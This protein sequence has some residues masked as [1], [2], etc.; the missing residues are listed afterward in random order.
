MVAIEA[1]VPRRSR[2]ER[3]KKQ[4]GT[5]RERERN[6]Q[7]ADNQQ[8]TEPS[9]AQGRAP[10]LAERLRKIR[11]G[12]AQRRRQSEEHRGDDGEGQREREDACV[13]AHV[14]DSRNSRWSQGNEQRGAP[15]DDHHA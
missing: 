9:T 3:S 10:P 15:D 5:D 6:R 4:S 14:L 7:L 12:S 13:Y 11:S 8:S 1:R 2:R